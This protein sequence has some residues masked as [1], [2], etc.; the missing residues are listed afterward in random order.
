MIGQTVSHYRI[1]EELGSGGMGVVYKAEDAK[2]KRTVALKFLPEEL[3]KNRQALERLQ[4]EAQ[5]ASALNHPNICVIYDIDQHAGQPFIAME[6]LE[7]ETLKQRLAGKPLKTDEVLDLAMQIADALDAAH[8]K[9][10][11]HR[12]I[13]PANIFVTQRGQAKVLDF[14]LA[15]LAPKPRR[16]VEPMG[17]S[18]LPT[19]S[20]EPEHL[21]SPGAAIGTIAYM[22][23][24]QARGE[25]LD[26]RT[27]LFSF[28]GVLYEMATGKQPFTGNTSAMIFT[29]ILTQAPTSPVRLNPDCPAELER[30]IN[31]ALEKDRDMR[32]ERA[33]EIRTDLKRLK[34]DTDSGRAAAAGAGLVP[35]PE[36][37]PQGAP[38]RRSRAILLAAT[39]AIL[40]IA[41]LSYNLYR[42]AYRPPPAREA[43]MKMTQLTTSGT[44]GS[45][46]ISPDGKYVVYSQAEQG[47]MSLWLYQVATGSHVLIVPPAE[48]R[49]FPPTFSNDGNY[50]YYL[51]SDKEHP[52]QAL[53]KVAS[54][55]GT[56][57]KLFENLFIL[58]NFS[59]DGKRLVFVRH[60]AERGGDDLMVANEDGSAEK[61]IR[62]YRFPEWLYTQPAWSP[63][64]K[65]IAVCVYNGSGHNFARLVAVSVEDGEEMPIGTHPWQM[66]LRSAWLPDGS[67]LIT[68]ARDVTS[69]SNDLIPVYEI[70]YPEGEAR[71]IT[72]DLD[73]YIGIGV[74]ADGNSLVTTRRETHS[75]PMI[76]SMD[77]AGHAVEEHV[78]AAS[79]GRWGLDWT[80]DGRIVHTAQ[81]ATEVNL[82]TMDAQGGDRKQLTALGGEGEWIMGPSACGDGRHIVAESNHGGNFGLVSMEADGSNLARLASGTSD[83]WPSC[84]P[85]GKWV[86]F[87]SQRTGK[88]VTLWKVS[89]DGGEP[90]QLTTEMTWRPAVSPDGKWIACIYQP[91]PNKPE[92]KL[93]ILPA[94]GGGVTKTF[95]VK[96]FP[97]IV[98]WAPDGQSLTCSV[99]NPFRIRTGGSTSADDLWNQPIG[100]GPPRRIT[101]FEAGNIYSFAWSRD[102]KHLAVVH[103]PLSSDVVMISNFRGRE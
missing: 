6:Y 50:V 70:S 86:A 25:E 62:A 63:D 13:K 38:F 97:T 94:A 84:S 92:E 42:L 41:G 81:T 34:R 14:G 57:R 54:L 51:I 95:E 37:R 53:Y 69:P 96:G 2:L 103:G 27:D 82:G 23:P 100:G 61:L 29:A 28:G 58:G 19:A 59:P 89:I 66:I 55:G 76:I 10:I 64:G 85:D 36:G 11:I 68:S 102:G 75:S 9:G 78:L 83:N 99:S 52:T 32:Y 31:K 7:G 18:A 35:G 79:D 101:N 74:T 26:A 47:Q 73:S 43:A 49:I 60:F 4:R 8:A 45:P 98:K 3:S 16:A 12:D 40:V 91:D 17:T 5:A 67:G 65:T 1:L 88:L 90:K 20:V 72:V 44:A 15:K 30:I 39:V 87:A 93:A 80:P 33:S 48:V 71:R 46:T 56:P 22:S 21:T 24:E 77:R